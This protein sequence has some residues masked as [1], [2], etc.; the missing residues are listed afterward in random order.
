VFSSEELPRHLGTHPRPKCRGDRIVS[1]L[2]GRPMPRGNPLRHLNSEGADLAGVDLERRTQLGRCLNGS[3]GQVGGVQLLQ[4]RGG[5]GMHAR[6]EEGPHLLRR[7]HIPG[8]QAVKPDYARA[9]PGS[10]T[11]SAFGVVGRQPDMSLRGSVQ[12]RDLP[13]QIVVPRAG[14]ELV[15]AHRHNHR[16]RI[17]ST[18]GQPAWGYVLT[19]QRGVSQLHRQISKEVRKTGRDNRAGRWSGRESVSGIR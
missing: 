6:A 9:N 5:E 4:P 18:S 3:F 8:A 1:Q 16:R 10:R 11:L 13:G 7:H 2:P 12:R 15:D 14:A 19:M 17:G